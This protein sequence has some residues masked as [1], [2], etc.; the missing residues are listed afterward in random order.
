M[1]TASIQR[2]FLSLHSNPRG[3][4]LARL[5]EPDDVE[6]LREECFYNSESLSGVKFSESCSW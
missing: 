4:A 6:E 3:S 5:I 1:E 2:P